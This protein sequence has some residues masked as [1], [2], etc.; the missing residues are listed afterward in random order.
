MYFD[1]SDVGLTT[2]NENVDASTLDADGKIYLSTTGNF[3][4]SGV[5]GAD[6]DVFVFT[7]TAL[8]G[9]TSGSYSSALFFD[10][11][12]F[13]LA[14]NNVSGIDIALPAAA[15]VPL[16]QPQ[17]TGGIATASV[18]NPVATTSPTSMSI[19]RERL[20]HS[21]AVQEH[22]FELFDLNRHFALRGRIA[23][24]E[25]TISETDDSTTAESAA[26]G[27]ALLAIDLAFIEI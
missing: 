27:T 26:A 12:L 18:V 17:S 22:V 7:P 5:S 23:W 10:G 3:S 19:I 9:S 16:V 11:S 8:G 25:F 1:A 15:P 24:D 13:G 14:A 2:S 4:V 21:L 6:E 20:R